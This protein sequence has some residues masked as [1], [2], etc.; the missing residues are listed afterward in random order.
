MV[1]VVAGKLQYLRMVKGGDN[2]LYLK[3]KSRLISL[4]GASKTSEN[5]QS[6]LIKVLDILFEE[7]IDDAMDYYK[8]INS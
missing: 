6:Q 4:V 3:L 8:S 5:R 7:G 2:K 1:D